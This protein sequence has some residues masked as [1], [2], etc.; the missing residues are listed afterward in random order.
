[1]KTLNTKGCSESLFSAPSL[2]E[3]FD[4]GVFLQANG[5]CPLRHRHGFAVESDP[6]IVAAI[7]VL[8][9][10][11][12]PSAVLGRITLI[13]IDAI[14]GVV[15]IFTVAHISQEI[16]EREPSL[17]HSNSAPTVI[18]VIFVTR[19]KASLFHR[20]PRLIG[21]SFFPVRGV[22][23]TSIQNLCLAMATLDVGGSHVRNGSFPFLTAKIAFENPLHVPVV[24]D[25]VTDEC[26]AP[27][28]GS[29]LNKFSFWHSGHSV[30]MPELCRERK[31]Y[32]GQH[33]QKITFLANAFE[34]AGGTLAR[35]WEET[36]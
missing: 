13:V 2:S 15:L 28:L 16:L 35:N 21:R 11:G 4:K 17:A 6:C 7:V 26:E 30:S 23:V 34:E 19:V 9:G 31:A 5:A 18:H 22:P 24:A 29:W 32:Y 10:D 1:M 8:R 3:S 12:R 27:E 33:E 25:G 14:K 20:G 36:V